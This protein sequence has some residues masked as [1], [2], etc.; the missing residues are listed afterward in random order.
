MISASYARV[1]ARDS[2]HCHHGWLRAEATNSS[3]M[4]TTFA[5]KYSTASPRRSCATKSR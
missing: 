3:G 5:M 2:V 4:P 1:W